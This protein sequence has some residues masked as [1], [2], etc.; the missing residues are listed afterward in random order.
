MKRK[1]I[2]RTLY[3]ISGHPTLTGYRRLAAAVRCCL[4]AG[5]FPE[6]HLMTWLYPRIG[7]AFQRTPESVA[8]SISRA[9]EDCW[10]YGD[11]R[12]LE[13]IAGR[14]LAEKPLPG[15]MIYLL[16]RYFSR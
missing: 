5:C 6:H 12:L 1:A 7:A 4:E 3:R 10:L 15:E 8:R 13:Q 14:R 16:Y 2:E 11:R 9:V